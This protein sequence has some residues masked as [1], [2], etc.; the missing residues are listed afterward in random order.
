[1]ITDTG[2]KQVAGQRPLRIL[3]VSTADLGGGAERSAWNLFK[4]YRS[5]GH[6]SWLAVGWKFTNDPSV[7]LI[8]NEEC[9]SIWKKACLNA[10]S[11]FEPQI[12]TIPGVGRLTEFLKHIGEPYRWLQQQ[13]GC[14]D[15][16][17]PGTR[18][19]LEL[20]EFPDII[21]CYN[22]HGGYF[23]LRALRSL[24][25]RLP[26]VID[27]RDSWLLSGHCAYFFDCER[28]KTGCGN[29]PDLGIYPPISRDATAYNW[30]RKRK[31]Y[32]QSRFYVAT[33]SQWLME[34]VEQSMLAPAIVESRIITTGIDR[35]IF[36]AVNKLDV[37]ATL[38]LPATA[39]VLLFSA[40][41]IK[42]NRFKDY[43]T[44]RDA[45]TLVAKRLRGEELIFIALGEDAPDEII[46]EARIH[47]VSFEKSAEAVARYYQ[48]ADVY[49]HAARADNFPRAVLEALC[50]GT[51]VV[52]TAV[53]G[54]P[55]QVKGLAIPDHLDW[56]LGLNRYG[57]NEA[58][59]ILVRQGHGEDMAIGIEH[60]L[61]DD[62]LRR[63]LADNAA[64]DGTRRF[65]L[66]S[67]VDA[68][69]AWYDEI[70]RNP[71]P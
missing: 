50:C 55:E 19:L 58:T 48:A 7:L 25:H 21:H 11:W 12:G 43:Q 60:L 51:P 3:L 27:L 66:Q 32:N 64:E 46:N 26:V 28:W 37:R 15:F 14:E 9:R 45:V 42:Q 49:L 16:N 31:V 22:L 59:G 40:F 39:K 33:P 57:V 34:K 53:G 10:R 18:R 63:R 41:G 61:K 71:A 35:A 1:V 69:L 24:S 8:P 56:N 38:K 44:M 20:A 70:L 13:L 62:T 17:F 36:H 4:S 29:C 68:Y 2:A 47:F 23:D 30:R 6:K 52:A 67:Q 65:D 5:R 54:I